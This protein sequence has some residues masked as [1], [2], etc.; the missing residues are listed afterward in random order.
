MSWKKDSESV[1]LCGGL[2]EEILINIFLFEALE[3]SYYLDMA[4]RQI[5]LFINKHVDEDGLVRDFNEIKSPFMTQTAG[6]V[7]IL[8]I[9]LKYDEEP[10]FVSL[11]NKMLSAIDRNFTQS[12][13]YINGL[14]GIADVLI[15]GYI[16]TGQFDYLRSAHEK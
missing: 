8:T 12:F 2:I 4:K 7:K 14:V 10:K 13:G 1:S 5:H 3:N 15:D 11:V 6:F 16:L 9:F